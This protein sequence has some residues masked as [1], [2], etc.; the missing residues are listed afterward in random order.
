MKAP[1]FSTEE[2]TMWGRREM[3]GDDGIVISTK[4]PIIGGYEENR[5]MKATSFLPQ[6]QRLRGWYWGDG[7]SVEAIQKRS[8]R[9]YFLS[10]ILLIRSHMSAFIWVVRLRLSMG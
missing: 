3:H 2:P 1:L 9:S 6:E 5:A 8:H 10:P 4:A 7:L